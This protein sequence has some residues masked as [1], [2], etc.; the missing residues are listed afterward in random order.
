M[1]L[2]SYTETLSESLQEVIRDVVADSTDPKLIE[3]TLDIAR[4]SIALA[5]LPD[6]PQKDALMKEH[7]GA[8]KVVAEWHRVTLSEEVNRQMH[9]AVST[10]VA[11]LSK[12]ATD[13]AIGAANSPAR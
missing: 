4:R 12:A 6:G 1:D 10:A 8:F 3:L 2:S 7:L 5:E 11:I 13:V 9:V